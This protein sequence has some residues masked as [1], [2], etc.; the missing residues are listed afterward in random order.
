MCILKQY[1]WKREE[2]NWKEKELLENC[3]NMLQNP[4]LSALT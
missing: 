4:F 1:I 3:Q 2:D